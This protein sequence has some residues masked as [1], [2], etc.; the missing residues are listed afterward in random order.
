MGETD[1]FSMKDGY[2]NPINVTEDEDLLYLSRSTLWRVGHELFHSAI[3]TS[4]MNWKEI[5]KSLAGE[6]APQK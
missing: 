4:G 1:C 6:D 5:W 3:Q 2:G